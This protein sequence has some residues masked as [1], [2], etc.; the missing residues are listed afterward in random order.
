[1]KAWLCQ[2]FLFNPDLTIGGKYGAGK[3]TA[4]TA[5][6]SLIAWEPLAMAPSH[7]PTRRTLSLACPADMDIQLARSKRHH[8][9]RH[10]A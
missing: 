7:L 10:A 2:R 3:T 9:A 1:M 8:S 5:M 6:V 4:L